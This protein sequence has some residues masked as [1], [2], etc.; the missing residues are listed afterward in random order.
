M[1]AQAATHTFRPDTSIKL[2]SSAP[3]KYIRIDCAFG[4][5]PTAQQRLDALPPPPQRIQKTF[6]LFAGHDLRNIGDTPEMV[7]VA[8]SLDHDINNELSVFSVLG[9]AVFI[10]LRRAE[11]SSISPEGCYR[12]VLARRPSDHRRW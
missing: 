12:S 7:P 3:R 5:M 2:V 8:C 1:K 4:R 6:E 11:T 10:P 9:R